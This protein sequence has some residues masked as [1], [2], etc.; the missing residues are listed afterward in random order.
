MFG[1]IAEHIPDQPIASHLVVDEGEEVRDVVRHHWAAYW[2]AALEGVGV[3]VLWF[4]A[5]VGPISLGA[6]FL[7]GGMI[8]GLHAVWLALSIHMDVFVITNIRVF[9]VRGVFSVAT[10][11]MPISRILDITVYR[12]FVGRILGYGHLVFESAAQEQ[13]LRDIRFIGDPV[14]RDLTIQRVIQQSGLRGGRGGPA[15]RFG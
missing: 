5:F 1:F 15:M 10:A 6:I 14:Q 4:F 13:G 3:L 2:R 8:L 11:T 7:I 9:R 12:P